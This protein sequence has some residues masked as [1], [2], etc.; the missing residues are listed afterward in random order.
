MFSWRLLWE[1]KAPCVT[2]LSY[3]GWCCYNLFFLLL[4]SVMM[5][6]RH[7]LDSGCGANCDTS[8]FGTPLRSSVWLLTKPVSKC[9]HRPKPNQEWWAI[10][11]RC[12]TQMMQNIY[13]CISMSCLSEIELHREPS[14][15]LERVKL[16]L[17][18]FFSCSKASEWHH[19]MKHLPVHLHTWLLSLQNKL[20]CFYPKDFEERWDTR[21]HGSVC[22]S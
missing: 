20:S 14:P 5:H 9:L 22:G 1:I 12:Q 11:F 6:Y 18:S 3:W 7:Q 10:E 17:W 21:C 2:Q 4:F 19:V 15:P 8:K 13:K 16:Q